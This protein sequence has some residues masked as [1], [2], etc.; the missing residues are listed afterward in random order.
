M[1]ADRGE[2]NEKRPAGR[3][4]AGRKEKRTRFRRLGPLEPELHGEAGLN[5]RLIITVHS[6]LR[7]QRHLAIRDRLGNQLIE[8]QLT[9]VERRLRVVAGAEWNRTGAP[10][11]PYPVDDRALIEKVQHV[12]TELQTASAAHLDGVGGEQ[13]GLREDRRPPLAAT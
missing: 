1:E 6:E 2:A 12:R 9:S 10:H 7:I 4:P 8:V 5:G 11:R 13:V 3:E